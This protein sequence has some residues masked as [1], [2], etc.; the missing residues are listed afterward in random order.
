VARSRSPRHDSF[1]RD[2]E[3]AVAAQ[4]RGDLAAAIAAYERL[5]KRRPANA[6]LLV[7]LATA[8]KQAGR[9]EEALA[10]FRRGAELKDAPPALWFNYGNLLAEMGEIEATEHAWRRSLE[11]DPKLVPA[12]TRLANMLARL[13]RPDEAID[14]HR[15]SLAVAADNLNS[16]RGLARLLYDRGEL[17]EAARLWRAAARIA[18]EHAETLNALGVALQELGQR[19]EAVACWRRALAADPGFALAHNNLGVMYRLMHQRKEAIEQLRTALSLSPEDPVTAANLAHSLLEVGHTTEAEQLARAIIERR[20]EH[21]EGHHMLG[22]TLAYQGRIEQA[23]AEFQEA[24]RLSPSSGPVISNALFASLY[25]DRRSAQDILALHRELGAKIEPA[26]PARTEWKNSRIPEGRG[27]GRRLRIGYL[28]PDFR[29]HPVSMFF[30]P[31]L[32]H[33]D[34]ANFEV[35]CYSTTSAPDALTDRLKAHAS[36]WRDCSG[37]SNLKIADLIEFDGVDI[38]V[39]LAG[40]TAQNRAGVMRAKPAPVQALYIGYPGTTGLPEM[41]YLVADARLCPP[42]SE[43]YYSEKIARV[44]GSFWCYQPPRTAPPVSP[45]PAARNGYV[46]FGS[47]NALQ[48][49]TDVTFEL[50]INVLRAVPSSRLALKS[51]TFA[52]EPARAATHRC[53][54]GAGIA[55]ER[56]A[57]LPPTDPARFLAEYGR[58]DIALDPCPYNGGTTTCEALWMGVPVVTLAGE[59]FC[60]RMGLALLENVGLPELVARTPDDYVRIA[61]ELAADLPRLAALRASLRDRMAASPICDAPRA[62]RELEAAYRAMW[63]AWLKS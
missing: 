39:D 62:A 63:D 29:T 4:K 36:L 22:F 52:D 50:W 11:L 12:A 6:A 26:R 43:R 9:R 58:L 60:A 34:R 32:A 3:A 5:L 24:H 40:H 13:K 49:L 20:P 23:V 30:E 55:P 31:V 38:L 46:T 21:A 14:W 7:N 42:G 51:L 2:F 35:I 37:W 10:C 41:D 27:P 56:I 1:Q 19:D 33:H 54:V 45:P 25:S 17:E 61:T 8:L 18:P 57:V 16:L 47:Y 48:K 15:R 59:R 44:E 28:S 53:F